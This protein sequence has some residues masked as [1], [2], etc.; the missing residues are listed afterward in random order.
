MLSAGA[1]A[2]DAEQSLSA[3]PYS[4]SLDLRS[5]DR[6]VDPCADFYAYSCGG[7]QRNN[8][9]P[10]D[11][12]SWSVYAKL[13]E[14]N[15]RFLWGLLA[16][17][18]AVRPDRT[19]A[20]Q[21]TGDYFAAC[22]DEPAIDAA[23]LAP[24]RRTL[25][26]IAGLRSVKALAPLVAGL[27]LSG[28]GGAMFGFG[29]EQDFGN[30]TRVIAFA[31]ASGLG[32]PDR[33]QYLAKDA[34]SREIRR[35]YRAHVARIFELAGHRRPAAEAA[36]RTVIG[37][38]TELA[39]ASLSRVQR[40]DARKLYHLMTS[41]QLQRL[42]P[43]FDWRAYLRTSAV[44][45]SQPVNV[46]EPAFF[47]RLDRLL[48]TRA[49]ADWK[50]Y[51][52]WHTLNAHAPT[53]HAPMARADFDFYATTLRGVE[54]MP[55]R[56]KQCVR[57]VDR[58]LGEALGRMFVARTFAPETK[59]RA[60]D[61][62]E[63]IRQAMEARIR[64]LDWMGP[65]TQQ[66]ALAKL[67][68]LVN[69]IGH[70]ER[71]RDYGALEI[72]RDNF[73]GN[74]QRG[75]GFEARRQLAK[76]GHPVDR[77][78]WGMTPPTVNAYYNALMNDMNFPAGILQ[79]PLFDP[80]LDDAPNYGNTGSTIG[81]ELTH[82]FDDEGRRFDAQGNLRDWW[83]AQDAAEFDK[84]TACIVE[85][86]G[87]YTVVD[88][89]KINARLTL[90]E[91]VADLGGTVLAYA[92]WKAATA[93]QALVPID[94]FTPEQRFFIGMAQ[95]ACSNERPQVLRL[96]AL[97]DPHSPPRYRVNGVLS[98]LPEFARAFSCKAGQPMVRE[99]PCRVW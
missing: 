2:A 47:R 67:A 33:E 50:T 5:L 35:A 20:E 63:H 68:T 29:S 88:D 69:K 97:A 10:P 44:P 82:G 95:W 1:H 49:L 65:K 80:E 41:A 89:I 60:A 14:D 45:T 76:I 74:V 81:H 84:R 30:S 4:P 37:M 38:E 3:L 79:P 53:L 70:P 48:A 18:A 9:L 86:Y 58:D 71:W 56:W 19:P 23:G 16:E 94:G 12:E 73:F 72:R 15:L 25:A 6:S 42:A 11:Q 40:R 66:Q 13:H 61:M 46:A 83:T 21:K 85:Q 8:P 92:A 77:S 75:L 98:N 52:R 96:G 28:A 43:A 7:W 54:E 32:L 62:A 27:H 59:Q 26:R 64:A 31:D 90:G 24:L 93:D 55:P 22:M 39:R 17:A 87:G 91:D 36:A 34:R 57:W 99:K 51:L 78:E